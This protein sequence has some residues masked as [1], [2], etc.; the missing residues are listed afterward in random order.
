MSKMCADCKW[1]VIG[2]YKQIYKGRPI[3]CNRP[4][5]YRPKGVV[6]VDFFGKN[7]FEPKENYADH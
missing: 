3:G 2:K 6:G 1:G 4:D 7:C 5:D